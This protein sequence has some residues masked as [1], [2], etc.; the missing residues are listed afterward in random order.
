VKPL[1]AR[2]AEYI[3]TLRDL[4]DS[5]SMARYPGLP[6]QPWYDAQTIPLARDLERAAAEI[7]A[8]YAACDPALFMPEREPIARNGEWDVV[9]LY[10][11]GR[12][13]DVRL[14]AFPA[15]RA[16]RLRTVRFASIAARTAGNACSRTS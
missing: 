13:H 5:P 11:R 9:L 3:A 7:S 1:P 10:E 6:E 8:E 15:V 14:H 2:F 12:R 16:A 4:G